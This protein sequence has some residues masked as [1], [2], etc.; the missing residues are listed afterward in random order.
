M[1]HSYT[2]FYVILRTLLIMFLSSECIAQSKAESLGYLDSLKTELQKTWPNNN[3]VNLVF[4]GHS[5]PAGYFKTPEVNTLAAYPYLVLKKVKE[6]FPMAVV[7]SIVTAIGGEQSAQGAKRFKEEVL[8]HRPDVLFLDYALNDRRIGLERAKIAWEKMILEALN[9]EVK[10][11]LLTPT[12]DLKES[13]L[14]NNALLEHHSQ[15]IRALAAEHGVGLVDSY[16]IFKKIAKTENLQLFMAQ[17]NH[18]NKKGHKL[19]AD[20]IMVYFD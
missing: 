12:P 20:A 16:A 4:H 7:N 19:V 8:I 9:Q 1:K 2:K 15:Q 17:S 18:I 13:I 10:V 3:T 6:Q 5:V 14:S 11:I